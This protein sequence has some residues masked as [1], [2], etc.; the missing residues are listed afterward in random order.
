MAIAG[1]I[2]KEYESSW[3]LEPCLTCAN[4]FQ[5]VQNPGFSLV[6]ACASRGEENR[7]GTS[8]DDHQ[9][10]MLG[11][12]GIGYGLLRLAEPDRVPSVLLLEPPRV[13]DADFPR[14]AQG[15]HATQGS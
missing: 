4:V 14:R 10:V 15:S 1:Q 8:R 12:A 11:L 7:A 6:T 5:Q 9:A 3:I 2:T 13:C